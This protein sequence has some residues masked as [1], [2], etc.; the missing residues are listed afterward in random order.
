MTTSAKEVNNVEYDIP[1]EQFGVGKVHVIMLKE[2]S[3][4]EQ[5]F[6]SN[7]CCRFLDAMTSFLCFNKYS[8]NISFVLTNLVLVMM[9]RFLSAWKNRFKAYTSI[10]GR[11]NCLFYV[12][13]LL[14]RN[15]EGYWVACHW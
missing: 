8:L 13:E 6:F 1:L 2:L 5:V 14:C 11:N 4:F 7:L 15:L 12:A 10:S 9:L 3:N